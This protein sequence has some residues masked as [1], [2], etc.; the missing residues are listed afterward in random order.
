MIKE[1]KTI[2]MH[3]FVQINN[4][5][6]RVVIMKDYMKE[7]FPQTDLLDYALDVEK[8]TTAKVRYIHYNVLSISIRI[9]PHHITFFFFVNLETKFDF[10]C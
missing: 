4:P 5:D 10:K 6:M 1:N 2:L 8:I 7:H 9:T 3:T